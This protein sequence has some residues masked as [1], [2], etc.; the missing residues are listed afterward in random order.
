MFTLSAK[1]T[2]E[3]NDNVS[4]WILRCLTTINDSQRWWEAMNDSQ[5]TMNEL[6]TE[7]DDDDNSLITTA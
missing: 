5:M 7:L 2:N 6:W 1:Q 4:D 3:N